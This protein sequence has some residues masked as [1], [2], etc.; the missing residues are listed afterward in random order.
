[1]L[2]ALEGDD[3]GWLWVGLE[4]AVKA[5]VTAI[6]NPSELVLNLFFLI[7]FKVDSITA[8]PRSLTL[9]LTGQSIVKE[10]IAI[11]NHLIIPRRYEI[12]MKSLPL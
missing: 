9:Q 5:I 4:Q 3:I 11:A 1:M 6:R 7:A 12:K 8:P 10:V 2:S